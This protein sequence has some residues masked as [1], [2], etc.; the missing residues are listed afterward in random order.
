[1]NNFAKGSI[2]FLTVSVEFCKFI[3]HIQ[4][5]KADFLNKLSKLLPLIYLKAAMVEPKT[6]IY[7]ESPEKYVDENDYEAVRGDVQNLLGDKDQYL[8]AIHPDIALS[9]SVIA[10]SI[11]EDIAD[12]YQSLKDFVEVAKTGNEDLMNDAL[13]ICIDDF[14]TFWG[15]RLLSAELAIHQVIINGFDDED[16]PEINTNPLLI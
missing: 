3:E 6:A 11:S 7:D 16:E 1:M 8:T 9:D 15:T 10:A 2:E 5:D 13:I 14:R 12:V 4:A